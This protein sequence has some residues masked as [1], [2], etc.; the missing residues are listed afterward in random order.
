MPEQRMHTLPPR[1][2]S[3]QRLDPS[4]T[5]D[6][7]RTTTPPSFPDDYPVNQPVESQNHRRSA[8]YDPPH[9]TAP[10][11]FPGGY[12]VDQPVESQNH[13]RS[14][15]FDPPHTNVPPFFSGDYPVDQLAEPQ[16]HRRSAAFDPPHT[17]APPFNNNPSTG[18]SMGHQDHRRSTAHDPRLTTVP[19]IFAGGRPASQSMET[20][21]HRPSST[22]D[23]RPPTDRSY[24]TGDPTTSQPTEPQ[25]HRP[26]VQVQIPPSRYY[27]PNSASPRTVTP[28]ATQQSHVPH[29]DMYSP[30]ATP[31]NPNLSASDI[32]NQSPRQYPP[33]LYNEPNLQRQPTPGIDHGQEGRES[34]PVL[35]IPY[36]DT[37]ATSPSTVLPRTGS[38]N[39][40]PYGAGQRITITSPHNDTPTETLPVRPPSVSPRPSPAGFA[41]QI[42]PP[43][44]SMT[45]PT[46]RRAAS[47]NPLPRGASPAPLPR[48]SSPAPLPVR[49]PSVRS[50]RIHRNASDASLP[51]GRG[52]PYTHYNPEFEADIAVLASSSADRLKEARR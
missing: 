35:P 48:A 14:A 21:N 18:Q 47:P 33:T 5:H 8:A 12:P 39:G 20:Q 27:S 38:L 7:R 52:S 25:S 28:L 9:P 42:S 3:G 49:S 19:P 29:A 2:S 50:A 41:Q 24:S 46:P 45:S 13:R 40:N 26:S 37:R 34:P 51:G 43:H 4:V 1:T 31:S 30:F 32:A 11:F 23:Q 44:G 36:R 15:A 22:R 10:P 6:P 17:T 16:N